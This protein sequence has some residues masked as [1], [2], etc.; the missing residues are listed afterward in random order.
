MT[1]FI[2]EAYKRFN[3]L[4]LIV[5]SGGECFLL[6]DDLFKAISHASALGLQTR[7]VS[8]GYWGKTSKQAATNADKLR[9]AGISEMN[10]STGKDHVEWVPLTSVIGAASALA[11]ADIPVLITVEQD[12]DESTI[13][14]QLLENPVVANLRKKEKLQV[15]F[16]S[17]MPFYDT[18]EERKTIEHRD[19]QLRTGCDQ[20]FENV[21]LTPHHEISACCGLTFEHIPEMKLGRYETGSLFADYTAQHD[22]F[23]KVWLRTEGPYSILEQILPEGHALDLKNIVHPCQACAHIHTD[24][25][26]RQEL[27]NKF[28]DVVVPVSKRFNALAT[29]DLI[30]KC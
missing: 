17:W 21:V 18:S 12:S 26:L 7:C 28:V 30:Y 19:R 6:G 25:Q 5:F 11:D 14:A 29:L 27:S 16:N 20:V 3:G 9:K 23:M 1:R 13:A 10:F 4:R 15:Q 8:N 24:S 22:D 2:D